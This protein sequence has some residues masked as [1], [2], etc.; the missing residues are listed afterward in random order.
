METFHGTTLHD[1]ATVNV[2][3]NG[4]E[5][6][7]HE[8]TKEQHDLEDSSA[9]TT[10]PDV[11]GNASVVVQLDNHSELVDDSI[12]DP[13][14]INTNGI[15]SN[16]GDVA[17]NGSNIPSE[18]MTEKKDGSQSVPVP[19]TEASTK[20]SDGSGGI[21]QEIIS[22]LASLPNVATPIDHQPV[23]S[24]NINV[25]VNETV[26]TTRDDDDNDIIMTLQEKL[27]NGML[28]KAEAENKLRQTENKVLLLEEQLQKQADESLKLDT[29]HENL[30]LQMNAKAEAEHKARSAYERIRQLEIENE[31]HVQE[32]KQVRQQLCDAR[33]MLAD[34][35]RDLDN[36]RND[37]DEQERKVTAMTTRLNAAKKYK[38]VKVNHVDEIE[39]NLKVTSDELEQV[40]SDFEK[41]KHAK[42]SIEEKLNCV[43]KV[44]KEQI[45]ILESTLEDEKRLNE[46]RKLKMKDYVEKKTEELRQVKEEND[47]LQ[48]E[49]AQT[50]RSL[51]EL[52][53]RWKQIHTQWVQAQTRNRELQRDLQRTKKDSEHLHKQGDT[54]EMKLSRSAN[55]TEEHKNKRIAAKQELMSVLRALEI[56]RDITTK[57]CDQ[58]KFTFVPKMLHQQQSLTEIILEFTTALEKLSKRLGKPLLPLTDDSEQEEVA[59]STNTN[60][61][62]HNDSTSQSDI[63]PLVEKLDTESHRVS[64]AITAVANN[65]ERLRALVM[66]S[67]DRTCFTVLSELVS[68]GNMESSPAVQADRPNALAA[69]RRSHR[70]GQI[71]G[72]L[73]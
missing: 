3:V 20:K 69:I 70:Y 16:C 59:R 67:G 1:V 71:P 34:K 6:G 57:L 54:L 40:K 62:H 21:K 43:E 63:H 26:P 12:P 36:V 55:E 47:S 10:D 65:V 56:E 44:A 19:S 39:D 72:T 27:Q 35:D 25:P 9:L 31:A 42:I 38:A 8:E 7:N 30:Q 32:L 58:I 52:N 73:D 17:V 4:D 64:S 53:T 29:L 2:G 48:L 28:V 61:L 49:L 46:E 45:D 24:A 68:K 13:A 23:T 33:E 15:S 22:P 37:R 66:S 5:S 60:G 18:T 11:A 14:K 51:V 41:T 50:N